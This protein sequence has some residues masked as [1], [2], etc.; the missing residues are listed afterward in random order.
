M[1]KI[2]ILLAREKN[3]IEKSEPKIERYNNKIYYLNGVTAMEFYYGRTPNLKEQYN[4]ESD[5]TPISA[6]KTY[7]DDNG[8]IIKEE[9]L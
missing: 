1:K 2:L 3:S 8:N 5:G 4:Y 7:F 9:E 6:Y